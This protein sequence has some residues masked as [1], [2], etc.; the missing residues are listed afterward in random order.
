MQCTE[1]SPHAGSG[2]LS[3]LSLRADSEKSDWSLH[4]LFE[5]AEEG[6]RD[7]FGRMSCGQPP[8]IPL[9]S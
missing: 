8:L 3:R 6:E 7:T 9:P 5:V 1:D 4:G 2:E